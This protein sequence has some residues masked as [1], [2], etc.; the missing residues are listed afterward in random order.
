MCVCVCVCG[1]RNNSK[2]FCN[3]HHQKLEDY[4]N[5][6]LIFVIVHNCQSQFL[7][8]DGERAPQGVSNETRRLD[9]H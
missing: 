8:L 5:T 7:P 2:A 1:A 3:I 6:D 4:V 9:G